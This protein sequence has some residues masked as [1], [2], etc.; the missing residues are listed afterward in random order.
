MLNQ[1]SNLGVWVSMLEIW[2]SGIWELGLM[3]Q[4]NLEN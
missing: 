4:E 2:I 1:L 3:N